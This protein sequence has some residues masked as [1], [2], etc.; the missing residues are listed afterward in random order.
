M[1]TSLAG[2]TNFALYFAVAIGLLLAFKFIYAF[3]TPYD[4]WKLVREEQNVAA[5]TG[6]T[7][8][9]IGFSL[10]LASA[11][12]NSVSLL[13]FAIWGVIGLVAQILAF[14]ILRFVFMPKLVQRIKDNEISAGIMLGGL[15][16][17]VGLL[18]AAC[19]T[20]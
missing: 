20:Y 16:V 5:A 18:N 17:A 1:L 10:A 11:A 13:D 12:A 19:M 2:L 6:F 4:E 8:A 14:L 15:S 9:I 3:I 7:G